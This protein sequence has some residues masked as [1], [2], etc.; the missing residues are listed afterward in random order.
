ML[1]SWQTAVIFSTVYNATVHF[2]HF[3]VLHTAYAT[4]LLSALCPTN[5]VLVAAAPRHHSLVAHFL[6]ASHWR[7]VKLLRV[8]KGGAFI[9]LKFYMSIGPQSKM[10][11][12]KNAIFLWHEKSRQ[13]WTVWIT[14]VLFFPF[15]TLFPTGSDLS[16]NWVPHIAWFPSFPVNL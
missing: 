6:Y 9:I 15:S 12:K 14:F 13:R 5:R 7:A 2:W 8:P 11:E 4:A 16:I 1:S 3:D 10:Q